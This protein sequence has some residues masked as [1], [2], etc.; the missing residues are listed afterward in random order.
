MIGRPHVTH[1]ATVGTRLSL[2]FEEALVDQ[3]RQACAY[4]TPDG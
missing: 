2:V 3:E 4:D 1:F